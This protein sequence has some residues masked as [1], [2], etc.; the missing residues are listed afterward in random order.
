MPPARSRAAVPVVLWLAAAL[1]LALAWPAALGLLPV[2]R[3]GRTLPRLSAVAGSRRRVVGSAP[4][5]VSGPE[6]S[7]AVRD[8]NQPS[9][10][11]AAAVA[12][13][14]P[15]PRPHHPLLPAA[16]WALLGAVPAAA[17]LRARAAASRTKA[18][19][20]Q[21]LPLGALAT[22][23]PRQAMAA[24]TGDNVVLLCGS[25]GQDPELRSFLDGAGQPRPLFTF[26][27]ATAGDDGRPVWH[28]VAAVAPAPMAAIQQLVRRGA[29]VRV[30]GALQY[31]PYTDAAG[32]PRVEAQ[33]LA[34]M[35]EL[36]E[37]NPFPAA[38]GGPWGSAF[39]GP[40]PV[41]PALAPTPTP[42]RLAA[43]AAASPSAGPPTAPAP[44][45][46]VPGGSSM[47]GSGT[48]KGGPRMPATPPVAAEP[49]V[50][51][52][53]NAGGANV[54]TAPQPAVTGG[55]GAFAPERLGALPPQ[56]VQADDYDRFFH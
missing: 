16:L 24:F 32:V 23:S 54:A 7:F 1:W 15:S 36:I 51:N 17:L 53:S 19:L 47:S 55:T 42:P 21:S 52:A 35:V 27:L 18:C 2:H 14:T 5:E 50:D 33:V 13:A 49:A 44:A 46:Q 38:A 56:P 4:A 10:A 25:V 40:S 30:V 31:W 9:E 43:P 3:P 39:P 26:P 29:T 8:I 22:A 41:G 11:A 12:A 45:P 48:A 6:P 20:L 28:R 37:A 34:S